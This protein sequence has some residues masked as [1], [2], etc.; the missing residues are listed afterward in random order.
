MGKAVPLRG[1][2]GVVE[3]WVPPFAATAMGNSR[4]RA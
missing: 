4:I 2:Y 1:E 3:E